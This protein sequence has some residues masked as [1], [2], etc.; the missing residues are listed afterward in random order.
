MSRPEGWF[1]GTYFG[2]LILT[3]AAL[4]WRDVYRERTARQRRRLRMKIKM[5]FRH[6]TA[7]LR[8]RTCGYCGWGY[9]HRPHCPLRGFIRLEQWDWD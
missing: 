5:W 8:R 3:M 6:I 2:A 1:V 7:P 9:W 4:L